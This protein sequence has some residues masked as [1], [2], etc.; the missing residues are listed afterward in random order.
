ME[1]PDW[2]PDQNAQAVQEPRVSSQAPGGA[3][4]VFVTDDPQCGEPSLES[5]RDGVVEAVPPALDSPELPVALEQD[6]EELPARHAW[7][8][9]AQDVSL[10]RDDHV[11][12]G[13]EER[14]HERASTAGVA[15]EEEEGLDVAQLMPAP[16]ATDGRP[17]QERRLSPPRSGWSQLDVELVVEPLSVRIRWSAEPAGVIRWSGTGHESFV[18]GFP[19]GRVRRML[20][21]LAGCLAPATTRASG[22]PCRRATVRHRSN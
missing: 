13:V 3:A 22:S 17:R 6:G 21:R 8:H 11:R 5:A 15:E 1:H 16:E 20:R 10:V 12:V 14:S 9:V 19:L 18:Y 2:D 4:G 7:A